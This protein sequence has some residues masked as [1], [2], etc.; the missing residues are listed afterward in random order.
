MRVAFDC[1]F[2]SFRLPLSKQKPTTVKAL[3]HSGALNSHADATYNSEYRN[4]DDKQ[5]TKFGMHT[6][7]TQSWFGMHHIFEGSSTGRELR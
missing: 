2:V 4:S 3:I 1:R 6:D 5:Q 7:F